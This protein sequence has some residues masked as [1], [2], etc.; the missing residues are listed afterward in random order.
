MI[1][2]QLQLNPKYMEPAHR[3][4]EGI[5]DQIGP[6]F[7]LSIAGESGS[8]KSTLA[9]AVKAVL[10]ENGISSFIFHMDD[11]FHLPPASNHQQREADI[12]KTGMNEVNL[13]LLGNHLEA[14]KKGLNRLQKPLVYY[15]EN[16]IRQEEVELGSIQVAIVE[17]TYTTILETDLRIFM[18]RDY[19]DTLENRIERA[20]D[21]LTPFVEH[22]LQIEH[23]IIAPHYKRAHILVNKAY[24]IIFQ[25]TLK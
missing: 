4:V 19:R 24:E 15:A 2:D 18:M 11:Y 5:L 14:F 6:K 16:V 3:I 13:A 12:F 22:V 25:N 8:G 1:G 23:A 7:T 20:R 9:M 10:E 17:G 21:P